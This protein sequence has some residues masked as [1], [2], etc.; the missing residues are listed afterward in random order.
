MEPTWDTDGLGR[1]SPEPWASP[2][3]RAHLEAGRC[4]TEPTWEPWVPRQEVR[5]RAR[6]PRTNSRPVPQ[7]CSVCGGQVDDRDE[8]QA[9]DSCGAQ[10]M[11]YSCYMHH[12][13]GP[14]PFPGRVSD[15]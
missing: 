7:E 14:F 9:C 10:C 13:C 2:R 6:P 5:T 1:G 8:L 3:P 12:W 15:S 11:C 4:G